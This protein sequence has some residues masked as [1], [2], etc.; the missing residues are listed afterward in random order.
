MLAQLPEHILAALVVL[1]VDD[2]TV[3]FHQGEAPVLDGSALPFLRGLLAA[4]LTV[5]GTRHRLR[6]ELLWRGQKLWWEGGLA[7]ARART[8]LSVNEARTLGGLDFFP[9]ARP[10]CAVLL[11][12]MGHS[13][14]GGRPRLANE[15]AW[16]KMLD[17]LGDLGP[18]RARGRLSGRICA[19]NPGH[20]RNRGII[21]AALASGTLTWER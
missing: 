19:Q 16:H 5:P 18:F 13:R 6:F 7:V 9:G 15:F 12:E 4:G 21:E 17:L 8:F 20:H 3:R 1:D 11:D 14:Y 10:G 2:C